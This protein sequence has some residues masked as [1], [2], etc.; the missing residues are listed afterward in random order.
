MGKWRENLQ[1]L[2]VR[3]RARPRQYAIEKLPQ[4][5]GKQCKTLLIRKITSN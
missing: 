4:P 3:A 2:S 1:F 5:H